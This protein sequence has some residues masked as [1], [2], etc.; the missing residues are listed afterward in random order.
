MTILLPH[1]THNS[2]FS[3]TRTML[4]AGIPFWPRFTTY[5]LTKETDKC[6]KYKRIYL[7]SLIQFVSYVN[8]SWVKEIFSSL[9]QSEKHAQFTFSD[10]IR[11]DTRCNI[12]STQL[13]AT[14]NVNMRKSRLQS[15]DLQTQHYMTRPR[16]HDDANQQSATK[17]VETLCPKGG[18][19]TFY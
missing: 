1:P 17:W 8:S 15:F 16:Q 13:R 12:T 4:L 11:L 7:S 18:F 10:L 3:R 6:A 9:V 14:S 5:N 19:F 2:L